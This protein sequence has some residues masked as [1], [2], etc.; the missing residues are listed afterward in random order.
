MEATQ[1]LYFVSCTHPVYKEDKV[2]D[3]AI[4]AVELYDERHDREVVFFV[5]V[6]NILFKLLFMSSNHKH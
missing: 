3:R 1:E 6:A 2:I 4:F 5:F